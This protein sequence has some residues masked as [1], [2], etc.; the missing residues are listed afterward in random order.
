MDAIYRPGRQ[1][2]ALEQSSSTRGTT[3]SVLQAGGSAKLQ[4]AAGVAGASSL[5]LPTCWRQ[6]DW[7]LHTA[8]CLKRPH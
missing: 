7:S 8:L 2:A 4:G 6:E 1:K 3:A 5:T